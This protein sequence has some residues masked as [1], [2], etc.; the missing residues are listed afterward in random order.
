MSAII[1]GHRD[2]RGG[3]ISS[4]GFIEIGVREDRPVDTHPGMPRGAR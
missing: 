4:D 2:G 1:A 3:T